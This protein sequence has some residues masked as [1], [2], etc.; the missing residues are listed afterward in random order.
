[1]KPM[2]LVQ[3][4]FETGILVGRSKDV[5][6]DNVNYKPIIPIPN[7]TYDQLQALYM[8]L[9]QIL[10][11]M[12]SL[13]GLNELTDGSTPNPKTLVGVAE[14]AIQST[15]NALYPIQLA[16][17]QLL[18][19]LASDVMLR[20]QQALK[21]GDVDG[22]AP[23]LN[24]NTLR[25]IQISPDIALRDYG[26]M[27]EEKPTD[28]QKQLLFMQMQNDIKTGLLDTSD[29]IQIM[30]T[31]NVKQAQIMLAYKVKKNKEMQFL[32]QQQLTQQTIQGQQESAMIA[33][34]AKQQ[35]L[36]MQAQIDLQKIEAQ[37]MWDYR[38]QQLKNAATV[39]TTQQNNETKLATKVMET[40]AKKQ[41]QAPSS[42]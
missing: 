3:M 11:Q 32:Q 10:A 15:N 14:V 16:E 36:Q 2:D 24:S 26:I 35:T 25:F 33:E 30:N 1:M 17:R 27:L 19:T 40:E 20:T 39:Q 6:G 31:F 28:D 22:Y 41:E 29:A 21:K 9:S 7:N 13:I 38:I 12:Q 23:A 5:M 18:E 42:N 34:Q 4:F 8:H 37:G